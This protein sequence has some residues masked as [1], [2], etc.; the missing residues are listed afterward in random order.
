VESSFIPFG[1]ILA[2]DGSHEM[3]RFDD[4]GITPT[5]EGGV[6]LGRQRLRDVNGSTR[7][8]VLAWNGVGEFYGERTE[9]VFV[10]A[11]ELGRPTGILLIQRYERQGGRLNPI[12]N[13]VLYD[14]ETDP[15][16]PPKGQG[17][18]AA[19]ARIQQLA[20]EQRRR[21]ES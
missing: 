13:P 17:R 15:L 20:E 3:R 2:G 11:Y 7:C 21:R 12:G 9:A 8:V 5:V 4:D 6:S 19:F 14:K 10:E 16:V 1:L 18:S